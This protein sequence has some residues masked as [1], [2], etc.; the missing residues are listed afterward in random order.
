MKKTLKVTVL[1]I[2]MMLLNTATVEPGI[3][4]QSGLTDSNVFGHLCSLLKNAKTSDLSFCLGHIRNS[5]NSNHEI[6]NFILTWSP[7][8]YRKQIPSVF[9]S[10]I[11]RVIKIL[12]TIDYEQL[13]IDIDLIKNSQLTVSEMVRLIKGTS[14][15]KKD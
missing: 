9:R 14:L 2:I 7:D 13:M 5:K 4:A 12:S 8:A 3:F 15:Y 6:A 11:D 10:K 1:I